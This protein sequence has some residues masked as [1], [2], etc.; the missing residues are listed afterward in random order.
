[1]RLG[2]LLFYEGWDNGSFFDTNTW[3][4]ASTGGTI[5]ELSGQ[6]RMALAGVTGGYAEQCQAQPNI[7]TGLITGNGDYEIQISATMSNVTAESYAVAIGV[8]DGV[9]AGGTPTNGIALILEP[10]FTAVELQ[11]R[12][13]GV[14]T[15]IGAFSSLTFTA[16]AKYQVKLRREGPYILGKAWLAT[17]SEPDWLIRATEYAYRDPQHS[18]YTI[19]YAGGNVATAENVLYD[20]LFIYELRDGFRR[21]KSTAPSSATPAAASATG[22][23]SP[24][25][26]SG[27]TALAASSTVSAF[28][29]GSTRNTTVATGV[30][31][32][33]NLA[34]IQSLIGASSTA[35]AFSLSRTSAISAG[36]ATATANNITATTPSSVT[37]A[38]AT[39]TATAFSLSGSRSLGSASSTA[40]ANVLGY[41]GNRTTIY[42]QVQATGLD[43][44]NVL[45]GAEPFGTG[46]TP[47]AASGVASAFNLN[48][49]QSL[50][51]AS[52]TATAFNLSYTDSVTLVQAAATAAAQFLSRTNTLPTTANVTTVAYGLINLI[53]AQSADASAI[54]SDLSSGLR[55][56]TGASANAVAQNPHNQFY[57]TLVASASAVAFSTPGVSSVSTFALAQTLAYSLGNNS[58]VALV[59]TGVANAFPLSAGDVLSFASVSVLA[60]NL[61]LVASP[62]LTV[63]SVAGTAYPL[64]VIPTSS[65]APASSAATAAGLG[66]ADALTAASSGA[67]AGP[68]AGTRQE[69]AAT[70]SVLASNLTGAA[71]P[72][73][74]GATAL[75]TAYDL[76]ELSLA[77]G[78]L[79]AAAAGVMAFNPV[80]FIKASLGLAPV[81]SSAFLLSE[82]ANGGANSS[83]ATTSAFGIGRG[84][85]PYPAVASTQA[86][87]MHNATL[88]G[89]MMA[90][91]VASAY[92]LTIGVLVSSLGTISVGKGL[93]SV[94]VGA[95]VSFG[96][97]TGQGH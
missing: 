64:N 30:A 39:A 41:N 49:I 13:A 33:S 79:I 78:T 18:T 83:I 65:L 51:A 93:P 87:D 19:G 56:L 20:N 7:G 22:V 3:F 46:R 77:A 67:T 1:M 86:S 15:Q 53:V 25:V 59:A 73:L 17:A 72:L 81:T 11:R 14:N 4:I 43:M 24:L 16:A 94:S 52:A 74:A 88:T 12:D 28:P 90:S 31:S 82:L 68:L 45:I 80:P 8:G 61:G 89:A 57:G 23:A 21:P 10:S 50:K 2:R 32:A 47:V 29:Q 95:G 54:A 60:Q 66:T 97:H 26:T 5:D 40:I 91:V 36:S 9:A 76:T 71:S 85:T 70:A 75:A 96:V 69:T 48:A 42:A 84:L 44:Q 34:A 55:S 27:D 35:T 92:G 58:L 6:G 37:A 63:A 62:V 38:V